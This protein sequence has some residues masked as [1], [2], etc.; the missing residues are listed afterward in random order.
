MKK[1]IAV[2]VVALLSTTGVAHANEFAGPRAEVHTGFSAL[3]ASGKAT[4]SQTIEGHTETESE[5]GRDTRTSAVIGA[6]VGYDHAVSDKVI[7]GVEANFNFS[8]ET[9]LEGFGIEDD[10]LELDHIKAKH[11]FD[12]MARVGYTVN[13]STL[14][15]VKAGYA[16][17]RFKAK[18]LDYSDIDYDADPVADPVR[19]SESDSRGGW[20]VGAG[21][22]TLLGNNVYAKLEYSYT[23]FKDIKAS[24][25]V[26]APDFKSEERYR[27]GLSRHQALAGIGIRF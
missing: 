17:T 9:F 22:E 24:Y 10:Y 5:S 3:Q 25:I 1:F 4:Y 16:N 13:P 23:D 27:I 19:F 15:Y 12:I 21:I 18:G 7:V 6:G 11:E 26:D 8:N 2:A 14:L 20:R